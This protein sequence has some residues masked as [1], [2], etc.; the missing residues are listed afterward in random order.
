MIQRLHSRFIW[1]SFLLV[2]I[3]LFV[4][5]LMAGAA[6]VRYVDHS[7]RKTLAETLQT[8]SLSETDEE[9]PDLAGWLGLDSRVEPRVGG[10]RFPSYLFE[11]RQA[12]PDPNAEKLGEN[13]EI[14]CLRG[15]RFYLEEIGSWR[16]L[17]G[18]ML[19]SSKRIDRISGENLCYSVDRSGEAIRIAV[20]DYSGYLLFL[21]RLLVAGSLVIVSL[22]GVFLILIWIVAMQILQPA[23][24]AWERQERFVGD[25]S[26]EIKTPLA[27]ILSTAELSAS[28]DFKENERRF[29]VI[30]DEARRINLL[31]SRMLESARIR[32]KAAQHR[33][34]TLFS[35]SDAVTECALRYE[36]LLYEEGI[37]LI[38]DVEDG[39]CVQTDENVLK[40]IVCTLLDNAGKYT[41]RG[42]TATVSLHKRYR[43]AE[44]TVRNEGIGIKESERTCIFD[45]FYRVDEGRAHKEG[46]YGLGLAIAKNLIETMGGHI[47]CDSDGETF[48][49]FVVTLRL[50]RRKAFGKKQAS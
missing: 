29:N 18:E 40:Q 32:N 35:L 39:I 11:I 25:A 38:T 47:R 5:F 31:I 26:H 22:A 46:S 28:E 14:Q 34:D 2:C 20:V 48:T 50:A 45:R 10:S 4:I 13:D 1:N 27:I 12:V 24:R 49:A 41:P 19:K 33:N 6:L 21:N 3:I 44:I 30:R 16:A 7:I 9:K 17:I 15:D 42:C 36:A 43:E 23:E 37:E 8:D